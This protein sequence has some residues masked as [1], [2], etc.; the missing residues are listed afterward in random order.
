[1]PDL[2]LSW[3]PPAFADVARGFGF[4][5]WQATTPGEMRAAASAAAEAHGPR[6]I[7]AR[8]DPAGYLPQLRALRG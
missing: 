3:R 6:L 1:M 8:V 4:E 5:A 2:G 7:D